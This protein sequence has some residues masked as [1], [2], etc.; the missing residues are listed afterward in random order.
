[1]VKQKKE[2]KK[3]TEEKDKG[4][5]RERSLACNSKIS[6]DPCTKK[7]AKLCEQREWPNSKNGHGCY[8]PT[9]KSGHLATWKGFKQDELKDLRQALEWKDRRTPRPIACLEV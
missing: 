7:Y 3:A 5:W 9:K 8:A 2:S 4:S 1:M 6:S